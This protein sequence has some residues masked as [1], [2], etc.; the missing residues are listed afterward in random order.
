MNYKEYQEWWLWAVGDNLVNYI[1]LFK[2][3]TATLASPKY[4]LNQLSL[5]GTH[6]LGWHVFLLLTRSTMC[7]SHCYLDS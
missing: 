7:V 1:F 4:I 2:L 3:P 5:N 6:C